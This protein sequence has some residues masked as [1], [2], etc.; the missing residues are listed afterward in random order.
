MATCEY[1]MCDRI[2][3]DLVLSAGELGPIPALGPV[4]AFVPRELEGREA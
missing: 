1:I 2:T 3:I 4:F